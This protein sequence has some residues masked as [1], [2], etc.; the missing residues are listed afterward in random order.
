MRIIE[1]KVYKF[2]ELNEEQ[3]EK[4]IENIRN[5]NYEC[6]Y[7]VEWAIDNCGLLEPPHEELIKLF[8]ANYKFPLL[9]NNR[10]LYFE[11]GRNRYIDI[12]QAMIINDSNQFLKWLGLTPRLIEK[13]DYSIGKD[14][15]EFENQSH[16]DLTTIEEQKLD[17][18]VSK[19]EEHCGSILDNIEKDI[20]YRFT[21]EA[22]TED[23]E[24]N[25]YE[26]NENGKLI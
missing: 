1:T 17:R 16:L 7:F 13:I 18:A 5:S 14:T 23:I 26:F 10:K 22:I 25:E 11:L 6:N 24:S 4:A 20:D 9:E 2:N 21:D 19:F 12:S 3:K 8:G 15:I